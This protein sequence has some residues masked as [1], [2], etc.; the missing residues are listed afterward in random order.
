MNWNGLELP[1]AYYQ[2]DAV[3]I[4]N[5]DCR[6][7]LHQIPDKSIDL[8]LTS[9]PYDDLRRYGG[10]GFDYK[11]V[12]PIVTSSINEGGVIVWV[13][14]DGSDDSGESGNSF[15]HA[16]LFK[17]LGLRLHDTMIYEKNGA[18]YPAQDKYYQVFEYMFVFTRGR[19]RV[20]NLLSDR[21]NLWNGSWG[22]RSR[23]DVEGNLIVGEKTPSDETGIR[24]NIWRY[25]VGKFGEEAERD[26]THP[27][28]FPLA[29]ARDHILTWS[30]INDLI[31]DPMFGSGTT[32]EV[33]KKLNRKCIGIEIEEKYC[34]IAAKRC[35]QSV[36]KFEES[37]S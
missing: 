37:M 6:D 13:V 8:V 15:R 7:I 4:Y 21:K 3:V 35:S 34:E 30:N 2:D 31:C 24:W 36:M 20:V 14:G 9:P 27:A 11:G 22:K 12:I 1:E 28:M 26:R 33:A 16:L 29:L 18:S 10:H 25:N 5:A 23:R 19:P 17:E 32:L